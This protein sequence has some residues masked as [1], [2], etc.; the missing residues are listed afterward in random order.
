MN[1]TGTIAALTLV[2]A[3][4]FVANAQEE[5][6][7]FERVT[8]SMPDGT[9]VQR[10]VPSSS[11]GRGGTLNGILRSTGRR[12]GTA[13]DLDHYEHG[14]RD[15]TR[16]GRGRG[17]GGPG[18]DLGED[19]G[20]HDDPRHDGPNVDRDVPV[21]RPGRGF[22][23]PTPEPGPIGNLGQYGYHAKCA[24]R[25]D[26]I[27]NQRFTEESQFGVVAFHANGIKRVAF[28]LEGGPWTPSE[29]MKVNPRTDVQEYSIRIR[30]EDFAYARLVEVRAIAYPN[31]GQPRLLD[32]MWIWVDPNEEMVSETAFI[33]TTG[34]DL[35]GLGTREKPFKTIAKGLQAAGKGGEVVILDEGFHTLEGAGNLGMSDRWTTVRTD[36]GLERDN[37]VLGLPTFDLVRLK[38]DR[39]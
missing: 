33:A 9:R 1:R 18:G 14:E 29:V 8:I 6:P 16:S 37:V 24:A 7:G 13:S 17:E 39:L 19:Y 38:S 15:D 4:G 26:V 2:L 23:R 22:H 10:W 31:I 28:S 36:E 35:T 34:S 11:L 32:S 3:S 30:P 27:P 25:W 21:L 12:A 20:G 5:R